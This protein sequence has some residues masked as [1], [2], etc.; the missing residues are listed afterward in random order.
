MQEGGR[1]GGGGADRSTHTNTHTHTYERTLVTISFSPFFLPRSQN[2]PFRGRSF[3]SFLFPPRRPSAEA[4]LRSLC[5][6]GRRRRCRLPLSPLL[7]FVCLSSRRAGD[8]SLRERTMRRGEGEAAAD[9]VEAEERP[10]E[11]R[12]EVGC[13]SVCVEKEEG[14]RRHADSASASGTKGRT[15][16]EEGGGRRPLRCSMAAAASAVSL[17]PPLPWWEN[18]SG[19]RRRTDV[20]DVVGGGGDR[21]RP[22]DGANVGH[23][24]DGE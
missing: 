23:E 18:P 2:R 20:V 17:P 24:E 15:S 3:A 16:G 14:R 7:R 5:G 13:C 21:G 9:S 11:R 10:R 4:H 6:R 19:G 8:R 1:K 22:H 12:G